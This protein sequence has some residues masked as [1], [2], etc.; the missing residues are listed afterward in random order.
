MGTLSN[1]LNKTGNKKVS[2]E[3]YTKLLDGYVQL[4]QVES[5]LYTPLSLESDNGVHLYHCNLILNDLGLE[6]IHVEKEGFVMSLRKKLDD[7]KQKIRNVGR[8]FWL[9]HSVDYN[10]IR[11]LIQRIKALDNDAVGRFESN[12]SDYTSQYVIKGKVPTIEWYRNQID[13][14]DSE[15]IS[16]LEKMVATYKKEIATKD[17]I[18]NPD[19]VIKRILKS[20]DYK[21]ITVD[22]GACRLDMRPEDDY[23]LHWSKEKRPFNLSIDEAVETLENALKHYDELEGSAFNKSEYDRLTKLFNGYID[24]LNADLKAH[25]NDK[26]R[27]K[28]VSK[29][30][31]KFTTIYKELVLVYSVPAGAVVD[32]FKSINKCVHKAQR[33]PKDE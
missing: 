28:I 14:V 15:I 23:H 19:E 2:I 17:E 1:Y 9:I 33:K 4:I 22:L 30:I 21:G 16:G 10:D 24:T 18:N 11:D 32:A 29:T 12:I 31:Q 6:A 3:D 27:S 5:T 13:G 26:V 25:E 20:L 8:N 7:L